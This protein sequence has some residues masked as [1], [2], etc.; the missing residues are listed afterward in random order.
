MQRIQRVLFFEKLRKFENATRSA[1]IGPDRCWKLYKIEH[2]Q[3]SFSQE[4]KLALNS[5]LDKFSYI[6]RTFFRGTYHFKRYT[7]LLDFSRLKDL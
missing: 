7:F 6:F 4:R 3:F 2:F 1:Q 5:Y